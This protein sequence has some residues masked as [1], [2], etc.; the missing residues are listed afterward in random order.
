MDQKA[1]RNWGIGAGAALILAAVALAVTAGDPV[2]APPPD[3][4]VAG[5]IASQTSGPEV[6]PS[7]PTAPA[8]T[9]PAG[10]PVFDA[11]AAAEPPPPDFVGFIVRFETRH[12]LARAQALA[13]E[14]QLEE[15][16]RV[17]EQVLRRERALRGLCFNRFTLGGA[18]IVLSPCVAPT[19]AE[20]DAVRRDWVRR[21]AETDGVT[22][23]EPNS[24]L[25]PEDR[26]R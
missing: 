17:A 26:R 1:L 10:E 22:Y 5:P 7:Q 18:E 25:A 9:P 21:L 24:I 3:R 23:A 2:P 4:V 14:G 16:R 19:S 12:P 8:P 13:A 6:P 15:G 20:R 11:A